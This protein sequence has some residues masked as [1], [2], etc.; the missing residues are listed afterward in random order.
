VAVNIA[1]LL[2]K[3]LAQRFRARGLQYLV[4]RQQDLTI[5]VR[6]RNWALRCLLGF[7]AR[8]LKAGSSRLRHLRSILRRSGSELLRRPL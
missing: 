5:A 8:E 6:E 4:R 3:A 7:E 1:A 2:R